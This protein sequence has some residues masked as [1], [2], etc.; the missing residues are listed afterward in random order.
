MNVGITDNLAAV[1]NPIWTKTPY[2]INAGNTNI[3]I[4]EG[5]TQVDNYGS[6]NDTTE[7]KITYDGVKV[8]YY[9]NSVLLREVARAANGQLMYPVIGLEQTGTVSEISFL[10]VIA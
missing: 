2:G 6:F 1:A 8:R 7:F 4:R 9:A 10:P 5:D 3:Q